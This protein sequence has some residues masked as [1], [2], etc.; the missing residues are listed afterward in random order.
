VKVGIGRGWSSP[1]ASRVIRAAF[2]RHYID[3]V[4]VDSA[5]EVV[6][7]RGSAQGRDKILYVCMVLRQLG[8]TVSI[9]QN[10][11]VP[12]HT[13]GTVIN[14]LC[15]ADDIPVTRTHC[16]PPFSPLGMSNRANSVEAARW[17]APVAERAE[18]FSDSPIRAMD[19]AA[20]L[21]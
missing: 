17:C 19:S 10:D 9:A 16:M 15:C 7:G 20:G 5:E 2:I 18:T 1:R 14:D 12:S 13:I 6:Q 11:Q 21:S 4:H 8:R 3:A